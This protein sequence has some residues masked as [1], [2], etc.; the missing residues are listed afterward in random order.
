MQM[1]FCMSELWGIINSWIVEQ[2][3]ESLLLY[4]AKLSE[5]DLK[6]VQPLFETDQVSTDL[7]SLHDE[8]NEEEWSDLYKKLS[9][10]SEQEMGESSV[11]RRYVTDTVGT[12]TNLPPL[13]EEEGIDPEDELQDV[14][15]AEDEE[16][17][18]KALNQMI[19]EFGGDSEF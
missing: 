5:N 8:I 10:N 2:A 7:R 9:T 17:A 16:T 6:D 3:D 18:L 12:T 19:T 15:D 14:D 4:M 1:V 13:S 11:Q